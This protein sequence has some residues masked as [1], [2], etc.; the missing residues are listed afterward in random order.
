ML[1]RLPQPHP[2]FIFFLPLWSSYLSIYVICVIIILLIPYIVMVQCNKNVFVLK[3]DELHPLT[4]SSP[5][6]SSASRRPG[7]GR[8]FSAPAYTG[9][10]DT[11]APPATSHLRA[12][13]SNV[14]S[15]VLDGNEVPTP[16]AIP[17]RVLLWHTL[18]HTLAILNRVQSLARG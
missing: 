4:S 18:P 14:K 8:G 6:I 12:E 2:G 9:I 17:G 11:P 3:K 15:R 7:T 16:Q 10:L 13:A 1:P 5:V